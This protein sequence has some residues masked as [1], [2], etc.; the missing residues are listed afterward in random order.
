MKLAVDETK[1]CQVTDN[2]NDWKDCALSTIG[3]DRYSP[4]NT[5]QEPFIWNQLYHNE[6]ISGSNNSEL[7]KPKSLYKVKNKNKQ[8]T[9]IYF[10][11]NEKTCVYRWAPWL[12]E[13]LTK[14]LTDWCWMRVKS[15]YIL[16][17]GHKM[18]A[19]LGFS[20]LFTPLKKFFLLNQS[21]KSWDGSVKKEP[22]NI[23]LWIC[24]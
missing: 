10:P 3:I 13:C 23:T 4:L 6:N 24:A 2:M 22:H 21:E 19:S 17:I 12:A 8:F 15:M 18:A 20:S 14:L 7:D 11:A 16:S 5:L 9:I 1:I